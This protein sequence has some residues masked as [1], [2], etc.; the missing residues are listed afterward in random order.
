MRVLTENMGICCVL[1]GPSGVGK[2]DVMK[3]IITDLGFR[4]VLTRTS[5]KMRAG[6][7]HM[8]DYDF[9]SLECFLKGVDDKEFL[10]HFEHRPG[11][12]KGT[13]KEVLRPVFEGDNIMWRID[14]VAA[15]RSKD[16]VVEKMQEEGIRLAK[17]MVTVYIAPSDWGDIEARY[18]RRDPNANREV[19]YAGFERDKREWAEL[20]HRFDWVVIN[21]E[22]RLADTVQFVKQILTEE[23][24][25]RNRI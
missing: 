1:T 20:K 23:I 11:E 12:Y 7:V 10:E 25:V 16:L 17:R 2:D 24:R 14:P 21:A 19:F 4:Q 15:A 13:P 18:F 6:E 5:R 9:V 3:P 8:V 22:G